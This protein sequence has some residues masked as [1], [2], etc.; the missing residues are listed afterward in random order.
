MLFGTTSQI[1]NEEDKSDF[2]YF[3]IYKHKV[4]LGYNLECYEAFW[5]N[6]IFSLGEQSWAS[7][8]PRVRLSSISILCVFSVSQAL[9]KVKGIKMNKKCSCTLSSGSW[10]EMQQCRLQTWKWVVWLLRCGYHGTTGDR[11]WVLFWR[12]AYRGQR[13]P[14]RRKSELHLEAK[15]QVKA[16]KKRVQ[17]QR[18]SAKK[19]G[20]WME[21]ADMALRVCAIRGQADEAVP[22]GGSG[23]GGPCVPPGSK[24]WSPW[25]SKSD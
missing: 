9:C 17:W 4:I 6:Q 15:E 7:L 5:R 1:Q 16:E 12:S 22:R 2:H 10:N 3:Q 14:W 25:Q 8:F 18:H 20:W 19:Q 24:W 21:E 23:H 11:M 13:A